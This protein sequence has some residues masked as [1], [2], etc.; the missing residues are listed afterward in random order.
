MSQLSPDARAVVRAVDTLTTQVRR[1]AD[2]TAR[3]AD[4]RR[5]DFVLTPDAADDDPPAQCWHTEPG[6]PC[7][8]DVCRQPNRPATEGR[9]TGP[10]ERAP[11]PAADEDAQRTSRRESIRTLLARAAAGLTP[12]EDALLRQ[13]VDAEI[14]EGDR[15][16]QQAVRLEPAII[17]QERLA[18]ELAEVQAAIE[19]V[20]ALRD[21]IAEAIE[22]ADYRAPMRRGDLAD[23]VMPVILDALDGTEQPTTT[24]E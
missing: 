1:L 15:A 6:S 16:R 11:A 22:Q 21:P 12:D 20:R 18:A 24:K 23:S 13:H 8:W 2:A 7:D 17:E 19:R 3:A 4:A 10:A 14:H 5:S 9:R